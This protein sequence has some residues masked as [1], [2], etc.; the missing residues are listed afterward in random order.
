MLTNK[1]NFASRG[2]DLRTRGKFCFEQ[3]ATAVK[4]GN[5][6]CAMTEKNHECVHLSRRASFWIRQIRSF[7]RETQPVFCEGIII[8]RHHNEV[9]T[10]RHI[11]HSAGMLQLDSYIDIAL[12]GLC[13]AGRMIVRQNDAGCAR[14]Q[15]GGEDDFRVNKTIRETLVA[16]MG[17]SQAAVFAIHQQ[18]TKLFD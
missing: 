1:P 5:H 2:I 3:R 7:K 9:I 15:G 17:Y 8:V 13:I 12:T 10:H 4:P 11:Q 18:D 6:S 16:T 14:F